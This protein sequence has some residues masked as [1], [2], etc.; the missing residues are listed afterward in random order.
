[1]YTD[2]VNCCKRRII[3]L[4]F[5]RPAT[6]QVGAYQEQGSNHQVHY[7]AH[8]CLIRG[9]EDSM[10]Y[11]RVNQFAGTTQQCTTKSGVNTATRQGGL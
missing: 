7:I 5:D 10:P 3:I 8:E 1:M 11:N 6:W 9:W 2:N 4:I